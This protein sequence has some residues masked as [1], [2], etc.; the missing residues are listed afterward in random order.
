MTTASDLQNM[1]NELA[2]L[3]VGGLPPKSPRYDVNTTTRTTGQTIINT[4]NGLVTENDVSNLFNE[5]RRAAAKLEIEKINRK[6]ADAELESIRQNRLKETG[7][8]VKQ[9]ERKSIELNTLK[10]ERETMR[11]FLERGTSECK[12]VADDVLRL[13][14]ELEASQKSTSDFAN[15]KQEIAGH[16]EKLNQ[17]IEQTTQLIS[18]DEEDSKQLQ[19]HVEAAT[20]QL[21]QLGI[22]RENFLAEID[23]ANEELNYA[24]QR[25]RSLEDDDLA[26][27]QMIAAAAVL[28][29]RLGETE[30]ACISGEIET[31]E[32]QKHIDVLEES[33]ALVG[34]SSGNI[35]EVSNHAKNQVEELN[36]QS[37]RLRAASK[38]YVSGSLKD[39]IEAR[40]HHDL[41]MEK[42]QEERAGMI[43]DH[44]TD[45][46]TIQ[47]RIDDIE[48]EIVYA[49]TGERADNI[50]ERIDELDYEDGLNQQ[51]HQRILQLE[52][53]HERLKA[54]GQKMKLDWG[55][56][57]ESRRKF[58]QL[59]TE[60]EM[61]KE[62]S[63]R[64]HLEN[65]NLRVMLET[66]LST[67][68][69]KS[70]AKSK[71]DYDVFEQWRHQKVSV[72][73][74]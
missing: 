1:K 32:S 18:M 23:N 57:D 20:E 22:K 58:Q 52:A 47:A 54:A 9:L 29:D 38:L 59:E 37:K 5:L 39:Y 68:D 71:K 48:D 12:R 46:A 72:D 14:G 17:E 45:V 24:Q 7:E 16:M 34:K 28:T 70:L 27:R 51:L 49:A 25:G 62:T 10:E 73:G 61:M 15:E 56:V 64:F 63:D 4:S 74:A 31:Y 40:E 44:R 30:R 66:A 50:D 8:T 13:K 67:G 3:Q 65:R 33:R 69:K 6:R 60:V 43:N 35:Q 11:E 26:L 19:A 21:D 55:K 53:Q 36:E 42:L 41:V 2:A